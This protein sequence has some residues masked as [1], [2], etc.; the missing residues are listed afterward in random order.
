MKEL[1]WRRSMEREKVSSGVL[2]M[3]CFSR[4]MLLLGGKLVE[5]YNHTS[6]HTTC[7][8]TED[9]RWPNL[10]LSFANR[11]GQVRCPLGRSTSIIIKI[12]NFATASP[13]I[14]SE[15]RLSWGRGPSGESGSCVGCLQTIYLT[16]ENSSDR[17]VDKHEKERV[18]DPRK[19]RSNSTNHNAKLSL[20]AFNF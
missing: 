15:R 18:T 9:L 1:K 5:S 13:C 8:R 20:P 10:S 4:V 17:Q 7:K 11:A 16:S 12:M 19:P 14:P 6:L 2:F 3:H